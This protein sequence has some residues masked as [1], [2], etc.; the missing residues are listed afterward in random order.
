MGQCAKL[1]N[2]FSFVEVVTWGIVVG[3]L[4]GYGLDGPGIES[5]W[6]AKFST[7][8]QTGPGAHPFSCTMGT[9]SF[10]WV[11]R[12][13]RGFDHPPPPNT[14]VKERVE[15]CIYSLSGSSWSVLG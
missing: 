9:G 1:E 13:G 12:S 4:T 14:E 3:M 11:K 5:R 7:P 6:R 15:L 2:E 8:V 10:S